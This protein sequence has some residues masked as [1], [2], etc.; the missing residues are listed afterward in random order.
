MRQREE[1]RHAPLAGQGEVDHELPELGFFVGVLDQ[2]GLVDDIHQVARFRHPPEHPVRAEAQLPLAVAEF[3][4][5]QE[6]G[7]PHVE[8]GAAGVAAVVAEEG[9][10]GD[11][12]AFFVLGVELGLHHDAGGVGVLAG[13]G[14]VLVVPPALQAHPSGHL[15][16]RRPAACEDGCQDQDRTGRRDVEEGARHQRVRFRPVRVKSLSLSLVRYLKSDQ[17]STVL[18]PVRW[19]TMVISCACQ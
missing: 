3:A 16:R 7:L 18:L 10:Q 4:E 1:F 19:L 5:H 8:V 12:S 17:V 11:A 6:V 9:R 14:F 13:V 2:V 15:D